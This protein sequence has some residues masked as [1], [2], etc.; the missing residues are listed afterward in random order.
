MNSENV[1]GGDYQQETACARRE[2]D[3]TWVVGFV[4]GEGCFSVSVHRNP[5]VRRTLGWQL[6]PVFQ[7]YQ[8][9]EHQDVLEDLVRFFGVGTVRSKG[10]A[11]NVMT[12]SVG[13]LR[14]LR[15]SVVPFFKEHPLRVK[16]RDFQ[17]FASIVELMLAKE[18][19]H[20][21]GFERVVR[22]AFGMNANGKQRGRSLE[23]VLA[24]SSETARQAPRSARVKIQSDLHGDMQS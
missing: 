10:P 13:G 18:H 6:L 17:A 23:S 14:V 20:P 1:T 16:D 2:L 21:E 22:L 24:G 15:G 12:Y 9:E 11:S 7:V 3:A 4:D 5:H 19:L 8:H